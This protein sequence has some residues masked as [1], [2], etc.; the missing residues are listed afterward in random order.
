MNNL[1]RNRRFVTSL[2]LMCIIWLPFFFL[3]GVSQNTDQNVVNTANRGMSA[4]I[5]QTI[6]ATPIP[7]EYLANRDQTIGIVVGGIILILI[8]IIGTLS[9]IRRKK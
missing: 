4:N 1:F 8:V 2:I 3:A 7:P 9:T 5:L 6:T